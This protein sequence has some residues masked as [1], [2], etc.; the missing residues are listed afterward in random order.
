MNDHVPEEDRVDRGGQ[1]INE[2]AAKTGLSRRT[3]MRYTSRTREE[4][5]ADARA[6]REE[7]WAYHYEDSHSWSETARHFG[8]SV[9]AVKARAHRVDL[10]RAREAEEAA[11]GPMLPFDDKD[12]A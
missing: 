10:D 11:R 8:R 2:L 4:Y 12:A 6:R 3:I 7:I 9:S 5:L 1:S